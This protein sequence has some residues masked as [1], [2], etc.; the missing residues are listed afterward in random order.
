MQ[1]IISERGTTG[2]QKVIVRLICHLFKQS[3]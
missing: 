1:I 2:A 3:K